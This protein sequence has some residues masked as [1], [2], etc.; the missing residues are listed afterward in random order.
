MSLFDSPKKTIFYPAD[1]DD[2]VEDLSY[3]EIE[4]YPE[5]QEG[6]NKASDSTSTVRNYQGESSNN[7]NNHVLATQEAESDPLVTSNPALSKVK[8]ELNHPVS[9][10]FNNRDKTS[11]K[12][13]FHQPQPYVVII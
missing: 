8:K 11:V 6:S 3:L 4:I 10:D 7:S 1:N 5:E 13:N 2:N 12:I 9:S